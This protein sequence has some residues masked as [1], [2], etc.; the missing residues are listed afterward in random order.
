M[1]YRNDT[2]IWAYCVDLIF[3]FTDE[4]NPEYMYQYAYV[5]L[6]GGHWELFIKIFQQVY[7]DKS[8]EVFIKIICIGLLRHNH[9]ELY[10]KYLCPYFTSN[11]IAKPH[12]TI[13][14][15]F[16]RELMI[17][18]DV[19]KLSLATHKFLIQEFEIT[20]EIPLSDEELKSLL[21]NRNLI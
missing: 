14:E 1:I 9:V 15:I 2:N 12:I 20:P 6:C 13:D 8:I 18:I 10:K 19:P 16:S 11:L 5:A 7:A 4:F 17:G 3:K 21:R